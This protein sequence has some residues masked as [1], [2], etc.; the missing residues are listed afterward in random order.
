M[1]E[2]RIRAGAQLTFEVERAD[3]SAISATFIAE[4]DTTTITDTV[5]YNSDG[6]AFFEFDEV[7]TSTVGTYRYQIN[8]NFAAGSPD[9]YPILNNGDFPE[10]HIYESLDED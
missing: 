8:E 2:L 7:G 10:L 4:L 3:P 5:P 9:K 6:L 1:N